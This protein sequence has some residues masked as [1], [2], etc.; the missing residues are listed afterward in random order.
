MMKDKRL[1]P[2]AIVAIAF[3]IPLAARA[4]DSRPLSWQQSHRLDHLAWPQS[5]RAIEASM[6]EPARMEGDAAIYPM[7]DGR[8]AIVGYVGG[9]AV[10]MGTR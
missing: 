9:R 10:S 2:I 7:Y 3:S 5:Q 1:L 8:T 4:F 6:G